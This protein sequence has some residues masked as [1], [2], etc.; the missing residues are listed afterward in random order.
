MIKFPSVA[1]F[2]AKADALYDT[3]RDEDRHN[4]TLTI[5]TVLIKTYGE[6]ANEVLRDDRERIDLALTKIEGKIQ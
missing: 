1:E 3:I 2:K 4:A 5:A 6:G